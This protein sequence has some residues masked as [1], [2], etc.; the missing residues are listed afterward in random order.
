MKN[1][2]QRFYWPGY[3]KWIHDC[4]QRNSQQPI[5]NAPLGT[6]KARH[7]LRSLNGTITHNISRHATSICLSSLTFSVNGLRPF[8]YGQLHDSETL[9]TVLVNK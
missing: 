1:V 4:Q 8:P 6:T 2:K 7:S 9:A 5:E 3:E